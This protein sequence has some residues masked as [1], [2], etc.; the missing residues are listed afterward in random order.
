RW[1]QPWGFDPLASVPM[2]TPTSLANAL[3]NP[4]QYLQG[5]ASYRWYD[6]EAWSGS[7]VPTT[8]LTL[9]AEEL[10]NDGAGGGNR[11]GR[12]QVGVEYLDG[13]GRALQTKALVEPGPA[14][15][16]DA[17]AGVVVDGNGNPVLAQ[18]QT[19]WRVSGHVVYDTKEHPGRVYEPFFSP[20]PSYEGDAVLQHIGVSLVTLYDAAGRAVGQDFPNGTFSTTTFGAWTIQQADPNDNVVA[21]AYGALRKNLPAGDPELQAYLEAVP[22]A[23]TPVLTYLDPLG[24]PSGSLARGGSTA[25]DRRTESVLDIA[26]PARQVT[27][28]RGLAAFIY[29]RDMLGRAFSEQSIDAG[30]AWALPDGY[31]RQSTTWDQRGFQTVHGYDLGDRPH[32]SHVLGGDGAT[33]LDAYVEQRTY[34]ESLANRADAAQRNLLGRVVTISDS[35]G[36]VAINHYDPAGRVMASQRTLRAYVD[37]GPTGIPEPDWRTQVALEPVG[38]TTT[39]VYDALGRPVTDTL[40]DGATRAFAYL[41]SG[42]LSQVLL[43]TPDGSLTSAPILASTSYGARSEQLTLGLGNGVQVLYGYDAQS[44]RLATQTATLGATPLQ[45]LQHTWD[46]VG[47]LVRLVD[48][49]QQGPSPLISGLTVPARRDYTYDAH[50]RVLS[51][52]GRVHQAL[53]QYDYVP[54]AAGTFMGTRRINL[55]DGA[56]IEQFTQTYAYDASGN[57]TTLKHVGQSQSWTT[58]MWVSPTSNRGMPALDQNGIPVAK[59]ETRFDLAG[60]LTQVSHLRLME[61]TCRGALGHAVVIQRPG[62]TDDAERYVYGADGMRVRKV[63]TQVVNGGQVQVTEKVYL[64]DSERKRITVG[65]VQILERW[66]T[67]VGDGG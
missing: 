33:P 51:A 9:A 55:N 2:A 14:I 4:G 50:Y 52:T 7:G 49:A 36:E 59:P 15:Q 22:H 54:G 57:L 45:S 10:L 16:R 12:I 60:N 27:D 37:P 30:T 19:R 44:H 1:T 29:Q 39:A 48:G 56:A 13:L 43:T 42:P 11:A 66:T 63:T 32:F 23:D 64:G 17:Q 46:P 67:H 8:V 3:A 53:L 47:N 18:A 5:A 34:G 38:F 58:N 41:Q 61:W 25:A 31:G 40:P 20:S 24:R 6:L 26:G 62:G 21:S 28:P 35:A 65:G